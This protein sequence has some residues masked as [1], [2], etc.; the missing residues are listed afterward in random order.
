[1]ITRWSLAVVERISALLAER[2]LASFVITG[3]VILLMADAIR[4]VLPTESEVNVLTWI[5]L[6]LMA[7]AVIATVLLLKRV[8]PNVPLVVNWSLGISPSLYGFAAV[9]AGSP[10]VVMWFG[11]LLSLCLVAWVEIFEAPRANK[12]LPDG[13]R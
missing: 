7:Y 13:T 2:R 3:A 9:L 4:R 12:K 5:A 6:A 1:V 10:V 11:S 8:A